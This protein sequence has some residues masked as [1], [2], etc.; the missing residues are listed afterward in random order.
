MLPI[1][2]GAILCL[3]EIQAFR[4]VHTGATVIVKQGEMMKGM[5]KTEILMMRYCWTVVHA[6]WNLYNIIHIYCGVYLV[7]GRIGIL[8]FSLSRETIIY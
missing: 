3:K 1:P 8:I 7:V 6:S 5:I 4:G 2:F